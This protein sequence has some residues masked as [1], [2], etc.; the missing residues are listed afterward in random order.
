MRGPAK[1]ARQEPTLTRYERN[2]IAAG[3]MAGSL[4]R[5]ARLVLD[6]DARS[7]VHMDKVEAWARYRRLS[8]ATLVVM[9]AAGMECG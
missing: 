5:A 3:V 4:V 2:E 9:Q 1:R 6:T 7:A 8:R